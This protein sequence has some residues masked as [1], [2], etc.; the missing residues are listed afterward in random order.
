M[1]KT[2]KTLTLLVTISVFNVQ[3]GGL[4]VIE[5][6]HKINNYINMDGLYESCHDVFG[7][8][9][10]IAYI[11]ESHFTVNEKFGEKEVVK[12]GF[13]KKIWFDK[14]CNRTRVETSHSD[15]IKD[16]TEYKYV[17]K[18]PNE[19]QTHLFEGGF[20]RRVY[21][22]KFESGKVKTQSIEY[23]DT[24]YK[25]TSYTPEKAFKKNL[26]KIEY[27]SS[28]QIDV[29]T[30][31]GKDGAIEKTKN[32]FYE[33]DNIKVFS[34][35]KSG[36]KSHLVIKF[37]NGLLSESEHY[38]KYIKDTLI[39]KYV[40]EYTSDKKL[41]TVE[42]IDNFFDTNSRYVVNTDSFE[43]LFKEVY[44]F[45]KKSNSFAF[46]NHFEFDGKGL[47]RKITAS[48]YKLI[49]RKWVVDKAKS[50]SITERK[51]QYH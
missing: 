47:Y 41:K 37:E 43:T 12:D 10:S 50:E 31:Y 5:D 3:S 14:K 48:P 22:N 1:K 25:L 15:E 33:G 17:S 42:V 6:G 36:E 46:S 2:I 9:E 8:S 16:V 51:I 7:T 11:E 38:K 28:G 29:V 39:R 23:F 21:V 20:L 26:V 49:N 35:D 44:K 24:K 40:Y 18:S 4:S 32:F 19:I 27:N 13:S 34:E 45:P 30:R